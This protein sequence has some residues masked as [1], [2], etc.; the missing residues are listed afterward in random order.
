M[1]IGYITGNYVD[2]ITI[3]ISVMNNEKVLSSLKV[4]I[5]FNPILDKYQ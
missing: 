2:K 5:K 1:I 4:Q 3:M